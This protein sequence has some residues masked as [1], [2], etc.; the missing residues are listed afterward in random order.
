LSK[1]T[2]T[3]L[4]C[5]LQDD[6]FILQAAIQWEIGEIGSGIFYTVPVG[7]KTDL[8]SIPWFAQWYIK[9]F[10]KHNL[11]AVLH[12]YLYSVSYNRKDRV[13][14]DKIFYQALLSCNVTARKARLMYIAVR[15]FGNFTKSN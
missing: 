8:A 2:K 12:D 3:K 11:A 6:Q 4:I 15:I 1:F 13:K 7:F 9:K 10:G 14:A 5:N